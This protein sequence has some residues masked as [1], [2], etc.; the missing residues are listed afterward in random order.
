MIN[1]ETVKRLMQIST[2][3]TFKPN[4][5]ICYEGQ[6]GDAMYIILKGCVGVYITGVLGNQTEVSRIMPGDFFGEMAVFDNLPRSASCIALEDVICVAVDKSLITKFFAT[7][8]DLALKLAE[9]MSA[10]IRRLNNALYK[11]DKLTQNKNQEK[12][13]IPKEY[14]FSHIVEEPYHNLDFTESVTADCPICGKSITTLNLK[15]NI[16]SECKQRVDGRIR[17]K[18]CDPLWYDVWSCPYCH[19]SNHYLSFFRMLPFKREIIKR[20]L[21]EQH[22]PVLMEHTFLNSPFDQLVLSYLEAIHINEA[23]NSENHLLIGQLWLY[24]TWLFDDAG[25]KEM[26]DYCAKKA[27]PLLEKALMSNAVSEAYALQRYQLTLAYLFDQI[28]NKS[29]ALRW[30]EKAASGEDG[31]LKKDALT[32]SEQ[33]NCHH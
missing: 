33:I 9:N 6:P 22:D 30:C 11:T 7:C 13:A 18:E 8:P 19:Y 25:D 31:A 23:I 3:K 10:R 4:E 5:Y 15:K 1:D 2:P 20:I 26:Y 29:A 24:L 21:K 28:G 12:F 32:L 16:M 17:Y 14:S 27:A